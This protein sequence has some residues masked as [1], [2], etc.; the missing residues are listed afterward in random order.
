[1]I[2]NQVAA[3]GVPGENVPSKLTFVEDVARLL[4][5]SR[6]AEPDWLAEIRADVQAGRL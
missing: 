3:L 5:R 4:T 1:M 6:G 2:R